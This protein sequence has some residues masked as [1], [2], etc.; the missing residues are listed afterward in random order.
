MPNDS[1]PFPA[2]FPLNL[3]E[4]KKKQKRR[5]N[6]SGESNDQDEEDF[7]E[8][9]AELMFTMLRDI[10]TKLVNLST[11][12]NEVS[13]K[14][15][16]HIANCK[17]DVNVKEL[18][19]QIL[20]T[21]EALLSIDKS[22]YEEDKK[23]KFKCIPTW[24][25]KHKARRDAYYDYFSV[26]AIADILENY[27][28]LDQPYLMRAYRPKFSP[29]EKEERFKLR[30]KHSISKM[31][32]EVQQKRI[33]AREQFDIYTQVD[34]E[35]ATLCENLENPEDKEYLKQLWEKEIEAAEEKSRTYF[36]QKKRPWWDKLPTKYPYKGYQSSDPN[37]HT[38]DR[39]VQNVAP[40]TRENHSDNDPQMD[41]DATPPEEEWTEV[42]YNRGRGKNPRLT[43]TLHQNTSNNVEGNSHP[44]SRDINT[45]T[46]KVNHRGRG[47]G[48]IRSLSRGRGGYRGRGNN[49]DS[50]HS[51]GRSRGRGIYRG[52]PTRSNS[53][54]NAVFQ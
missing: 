33:T 39:E 5:R 20:S 49:T 3:L 13:N 2:T 29:G 41:V 32:L 16:N 50:T 42:N 54:S 27:A 26:S 11:T 22:Q 30:E 35:M 1:Q 31:M 34:E 43:R 44:I 45:N 21:Q 36:N 28:T 15:D 51:R 46:K 4:S 24:G 25:E 8:T 47:R 18:K 14:L 40:T 7:E 17:T 10:Q 9:P 37:T 12:V 6:T 23:R 53:N 19:E 52:K 38:T 48:T